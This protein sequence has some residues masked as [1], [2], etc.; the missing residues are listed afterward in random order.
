MPLSLFSSR[1]VTSAN[2]VMLLLGVVFFSMWYFLSL[3]LQDVHG[4]GPLKAGLLFLPMS[5]AII[6]GAQTAGRTLARFGPRRLLFVGL[7]FGTAG[8]AWLTQLGA[9]S[10]YVGGLLGGTLLISF[11]TGLSFAPLASAA[12]TGVHWTQ[13]GLASGVLN[14]SRQVG[15]SIGL[16]ALATVATDRTNHFS[17]SGPAAALTAGYDRAFMVAAIIAAVAALC[18]LRIPEPAKQTVVEPEPY[19]AVAD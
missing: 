16:A 18:A 13:A 4:Y 15:G 14:T 6:A 3:Y 2:I 11:G 19:V 17:G 12:T 8:F 7:V 1:W 9:T 5:V 10:S